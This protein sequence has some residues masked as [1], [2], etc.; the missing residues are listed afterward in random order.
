MILKQIWLSFYT[1]V[2]C[3]V[4]DEPIKGKQKRDFL[5]HILHNFLSISSLKTLV[6]RMC[7][8]CFLWTRDSGTCQDRK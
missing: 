1:H 7:R 5:L 8:V 6:Y 4:L 3:F 2:S